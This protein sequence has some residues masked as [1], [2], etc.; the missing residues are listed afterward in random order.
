MRIGR[1]KGIKNIGAFANFQNGSSLG[2]EKLT[3][4]YGLNTYGKTTLAD[5]FES[6]KSNNPEIIYSRKTRNQVVSAT[7][8]KVF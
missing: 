8:L 7:L 6:L 5:I 4:I 3:F 2:F 1:I